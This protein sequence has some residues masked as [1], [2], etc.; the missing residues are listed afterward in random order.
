VCVITQ[1]QLGLGLHCSVTTSHAGH[2]RERGGAPAGQLPRAAPTL[3]WRHVR[4]ESA[5]GGRGVGVP[6][7]DDRH[8]VAD[9]RRRR[10]GRLRGGGRTSGVRGGHRAGRRG[11]GVLPGAQPRL[12]TGAPGGDAAGAGAPVPPAGRGQAKR[13]ARRLLPLGHPHRDVATAAV[14]WSE[15]FHVPLAGISGNAFNFGGLTTLRCVLSST[16]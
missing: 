3:R 5:G 15:A 13:P 1:L 2:R 9:E 11:V 16:A 6:A 4:R 10:F 8:R 14:S 7:P 12:A